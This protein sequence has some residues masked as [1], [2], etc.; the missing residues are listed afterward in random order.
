MSSFDEQDIIAAEKNTTQDDNGEF[1]ISDRE[2]LQMELSE[3]QV[4][5]IE[6]QIEIVNAEARI[7]ASATGDG[8]ESNPYV[9]AAGKSK[10]VTAKSAW[11][12]C[13]TRGAVDFD[14]SAARSGSTFKVYKKTLLGKKSLLSG[15]GTI[16][17]ETLS[18]CA[19]NNGANTFLI[20]VSA[21]GSTLIDCLVSEHVDTKSNSN[22][23][24][25]TPDDDSAI[26]DTNI[27]Y[28]KYW[29][30]DK[31][32]VGEIRDMVSHSDFL[33]LQSSVVN[34]T[35]GLSMF[36][37]G[38]GLPK[39]STWLG[40]AGVV[41]SFASPVDFKESVLDDIDDV[42]GYKGMENGHAVYTRGCLIKE[43][44]SNGYTFYEVTA[45]SG[46]TMRGPQGWTGTWQ[47]NN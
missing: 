10:A 29:Y 39:T 37:A 23:A 38:L 9:L 26:Y 11:F 44:M 47:V 40:V 8:S 46:G 6:E 4:A 15:D 17:K 21:T 22:G 41:T 36:L 28:F 27:L 2:S 16:F 13:E 34:G 43:Y 33:D 1:Y 32:R 19:I 3:E 42:A 30:V 31:M 45:W 14:V 5:A 24:L 35:L 25:W 20:S 12:K 7:S 18:D